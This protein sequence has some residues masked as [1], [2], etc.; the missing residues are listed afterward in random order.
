MRWYARYR[1]EAFRV[2]V[3]PV[4]RLVGISVDQQGPVIARYREAAG[5][6]AGPGLREAA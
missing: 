1:L 2:P 6:V 5:R 3:V 4:D